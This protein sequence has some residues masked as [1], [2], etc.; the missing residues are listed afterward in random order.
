MAGYMDDDWLPP[1]GS[2]EE[3]DM[4]CLPCERPEEGDGEA[5]VVLPD[6]G[7]V[8]FWTEVYTHQRGRELAPQ[9]WLL[10][11]QHFCAQGWRRF[12]DAAVRASGPGPRILDLGCGDADFMSEAYD[13]GY[14]DITGV[15]IV[16]EVLE[17]MRQKNATQRPNMKYVLADACDLTSTLEAKDFDVV[18]DKSTLDALK[19][20]GPEATGRMSS[21]VH[22][23]LQDDGVYLCV[24]LN[25][26]EDAQSAIESTAHGERWEV[27]VLV[28]ENENYEGRR[29]GPPKHLYMYV[30]RKQQGKAECT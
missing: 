27:E 6:Y 23:I 20:R 22:R 13:D 4:G 16:E 18:F 12:F 26:P 8:N 9:E 24:S 3:Q 28:C 10:S 19:C 1:S 15:D 7:D 30:A 5:D 17:T 21:E 11:Y 29:D 2:E 14:Q 25:P